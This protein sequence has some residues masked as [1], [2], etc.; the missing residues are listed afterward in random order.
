[1]RNTRTMMD[2]CWRKKTQW[3][4]HINIQ[5]TT[6]TITFLFKILL[7]NNNKDFLQVN[8]YPRLRHSRF[9]KKDLIVERKSTDQTLPPSKGKK[10]AREVKNYNPILDSCYSRML[11]RIRKIRN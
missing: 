6:V 3:I 2:T 8:L 10:E 7:K 11:I 4:D 9:N 1:M 5:L